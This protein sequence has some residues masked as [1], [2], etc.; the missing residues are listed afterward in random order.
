MTNTKGKLVQFKSRAAQVKDKAIDKAVEIM[1]SIDA[2]SQSAE[3]M[4]LIVLVV[5]LVGAFFAPQIT[6]WFTDVM[7]DLA[8]HTDNIFNFSAAA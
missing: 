1:H 6:A 7:G 3:T 5:A 4:L 8:T 2:I